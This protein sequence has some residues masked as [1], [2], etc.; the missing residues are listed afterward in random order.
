VE[1]KRAVPRSEIAK[2]ISATCNTRQYMASP[3]GN[4]TLVG[5]YPSNLKSPGMASYASPPPQIPQNKSSTSLASYT[6][7][8]SGGSYNPMY[9]SRGAS[10]PRI[11]MEEYAY[12]KVFVGGLHYDTRDGKY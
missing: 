9:D 3:S 11:N 4:S 12:N 5:G 10:D 1:A 8:S 7:V 6:S 2:E